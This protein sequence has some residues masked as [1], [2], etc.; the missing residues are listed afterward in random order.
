MHY[1]GNRQNPQS[2][3]YKPDKRHKNFHVTTSTGRNPRTHSET[4]R[5]DRK[6]KQRPRKKKRVNEIMRYIKK[7]S[8]WRIMSDY[9]D[10]FPEPPP[11]AKTV[12]NDLPK[13]FSKQTSQKKIVVN[14][15]STS[16]EIQLQ[17]IFRQT[18]LLFDANIFPI[19]ISPV[20]DCRL[21]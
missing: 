14:T 19:D 3:V 5:T 12:S 10:E 18:G 21:K 13:E 2:Q 16:V 4:P 15:T 8:N 17:K 7:S 11:S 20:S 9:N 1:T 6:V